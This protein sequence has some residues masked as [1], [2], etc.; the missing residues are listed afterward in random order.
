MDE[1]LKKRMMEEY[2]CP[3]VCKECEGVL[4]YKGLGEYKCE[5]C[6][7]VEYDDYGKVRNYLDEHRGANVTQISESTGVSH[8]SIR[9]MIKENRFEV[10]DSRGGYIRCEMWGEY[11]QRQALRKVRGNLSPPGGGGCPD[12]PEGEGAEQERKRCR[13]AG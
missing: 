4:V 9:D 8:K 2:D 11:K 13:H 12:S 7:A 5:N 10:I 1:T 6:G 3:V